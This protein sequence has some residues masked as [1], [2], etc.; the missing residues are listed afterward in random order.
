MAR[1]LIMEDEKPIRHLYAEMLKN[2]HQ[3]EFAA[4]GQEGYDK[5]LAGHYDLVVSDLNMP[6]WSGADAMATIDAL[7]PGQKY[8]VVS[9]YLQQG[10]YQTLLATVPNIM[11]QLQKPFDKATLVAAI[12]EAL[13]QPLKQAPAPARAAVA[14]VASGAGHGRPSGRASASAFGNM[15]FIAWGAG[16]AAL[17]VAGTFLPVYSTESYGGSSLWGI[18]PNASLLVIVLAVM[19]ALFTFL[20][21]KQQVLL[22]GLSIMALVSFTFIHYQISLSD[23]RSGVV[24]DFADSPFHAIASD[25]SNPMASF[26]ARQIMNETR[27]EFWAWAACF[28]GS[29]MMSLISFLGVL[30]RR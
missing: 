22:V 26:D 4:T 12:D 15:E 17:C 8:L 30:S 18:S 1:L 5:A 14:P 9:G 25:T 29:G 7:K 2:D 19:G 6:S 3:L 23:I 11:G 27:Q 13:R 20:N 10:E 24:G 21:K 16:G 28:L